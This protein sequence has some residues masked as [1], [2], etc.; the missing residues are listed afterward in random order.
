MALFLFLVPFIGEA[1]EDIPKGLIF[2]LGAVLTLLC[3]GFAVVPEL[4]IYG[5]RRR[6]RWGWILG[7][8]IG[9]LYTPSGF[10]FLG[11]QN[12]ATSCWN[13]FG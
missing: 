3:A 9:G 7:L 4:A 5:L 11:I 12:H 10:F 6:K 13:G 2:F 8:I 1:E